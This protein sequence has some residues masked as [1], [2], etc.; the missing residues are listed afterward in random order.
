[1]IDD[2]V[3]E[4]L[5]KGPTRKELERTKTKTNAS[6]I[7]GYEKIGGFGGKATA[8][9]QSELYAGDPGFYK[10]YLTWMNEAGVKDVDRQANKWLGKGYYQILSLIHI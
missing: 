9:A 6:V 2:I 8:L 3:Q 5:T 10:T 7:R 4:F 1:M